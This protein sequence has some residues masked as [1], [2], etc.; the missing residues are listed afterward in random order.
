M[1]QEVQMKKPEV[2]NSKKPLLF[3][4]LLITLLLLITI[5]LAA[6]LI[7]TLGNQNTNNSTLNNTQTENNPQETSQEEIPANDQP[8]TELETFNLE[9]YGGLNFE[10]DKSKWDVEE[11]VR[12]PDSFVTLTLKSDPSINFTIIQTWVPDITFFRNL[13]YENDCAE[14]ANVV[15]IKPSEFLYEGEG[16][17]SS[18]FHTSGLFRMTNSDGSISYGSN[19]SVVKQ[20]TNYD[21]KYFEDGYCFHSYGT[22][23]REDGG[24]YILAVVNLTNP[25]LTNNTELVREIDEIAKS[26][27]FKVYS[28]NTN[29][30]STKPGDLPL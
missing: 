26:L 2:K 5:V 10:Y 22:I 13:T 23:Q 11:E 18:G 12:V 17:D 25:S 9:H 14:K 4:G 3:A 21:N 28:L 29:L 8:A 27:N 15:I 7:I 19:M 24:S 6:L 30:I 16:I 20:F 1:E